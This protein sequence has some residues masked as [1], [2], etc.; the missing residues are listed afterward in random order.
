MNHR[1][2]ARGCPWRVMHRFRWHCK[3]LNGQPNG[4]LCEETNC[5]GLHIADI[6]VNELRAE[7]YKILGENNENAASIAASAGGDQS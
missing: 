7:I 4:S 1:M 5:A 2:M 3:S 6:M